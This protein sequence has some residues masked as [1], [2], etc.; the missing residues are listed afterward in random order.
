[1]KRPFPYFV[2]VLYTLLFI[3][4][5]GACSSSHRPVEELLEKAES[6]IWTQADSSLV[7]LESIRTP[8]ELTGKEQADYALLLSQAM[9]RC[10][11]PAASDSLIN[12]AVSYYRQKGGADKAG[13][14][15]YLKGGIWRNDLKDRSKAVRRDIYH[16]EV[17]S[18]KGSL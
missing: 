9:Y 12:V 4:L 3:I 16:F 15:L 17:P 18:S 10:F 11:K 7:L 1:M 14:S 5:F 6:M 2:K 13:L 8:H